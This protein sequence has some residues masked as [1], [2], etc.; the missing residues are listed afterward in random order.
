MM[1][2]LLAGIGLVL[3][4]VGIVRTLVCVTPASLCGVGA[5]LAALAGAVSRERVGAFA[6]LALVAVVAGLV[7]P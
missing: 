6:L 3:L 7:I 5:G 4:A 2:A 1:R